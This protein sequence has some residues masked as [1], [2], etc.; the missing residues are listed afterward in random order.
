MCAQAAERA[1]PAGPTKFAADGTRDADRTGLQ[2]VSA[3]SIVAKPPLHKM[4]N[5]ER[6]DQF[7]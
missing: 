7:D 6:C 5:R 2:H 3:P 1:I 4:T